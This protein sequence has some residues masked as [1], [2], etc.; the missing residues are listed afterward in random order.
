MA[1][2]TPPP[3]DAVAI[4]GVTAATCAGGAGKA[5]VATAKGPAASSGVALNAGTAV[6]SADGEDTIQAADTPKSGQSTGPATER[7]TGPAQPKTLDSATNDPSA[8]DPNGQASAPAVGASHDDVAASGPGE[9][10]SRPVAHPGKD[11]AP[12][13]KAAGEHADFGV[14]VI[15]D[16]GAA[17]TAN[18]NAPA[19]QT[20]PSGDQ[21]T[22]AAVPA[23]GAN[24]IGDAGKTS[25]ASPPALQAAATA[26]AM[27]IT[28]VPIEIAGRA[29]AGSNRFE[30]RL[31]PP[32]LGRID[33]RLNVDKQGNVTSHLVVERSATLDMLRRD[34]PQLERALQDAGLKTGSDGLQFSLR[35]Q[36]G[37]AQ[38]QNYQDN[39]MTRSARL[40]IPTDDA[41][42]VESARSYGRLVGARGG[43]DIR[44]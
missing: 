9:D 42:V 17:T 13:T 19:G 18:V 16:K 26:A 44:V 15:G 4:A 21:A 37:G 34:A 6:G 35:D 11:P 12:A 33:V 36:G 14:G 39:Q 27:P 10:D 25:P 31:D 29:L 5:S 3:T 23:A 28:G 2:Q 41:A 8:L 32:D 40:I 43:V 1:S 7:N 30:I 20:A 24:A 38:N 22:A